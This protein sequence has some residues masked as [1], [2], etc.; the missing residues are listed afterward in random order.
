MRRV[1]LLIAAARRNTDNVDFD[2][3]RGI[4]DES[5]LEW[6]NEGQ[7]KLQA[8]IIGV[9]ADLFSTQKEIA[10]VSQQEVYI[11]PSDTYQNT[12]ALG[13]AFSISGLAKDYYSLNKGS[14]KDRQTGLFGSP[15]RYIPRGKQFL[16]TLVPTT[17]T[18]RVDYIGTIPRLDKRRA[19]V[20]AVTLGAGGITSLT[21]DFAN[22]DPDNYSALT[23]EGFATAVDLDGNQKMLAIPLDAI[24]STTGIVTV[25][26]G[27]LYGVGETLAVGNYLLCGNDSTTHS[28]L[29][30]HCEQYL[31]RTMELYALNKDSSADD[32]EW[33]RELVDLETEIVAG[34]A[35]QN[36]DTSFPVVTDYDYMDQE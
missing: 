9:H 13:V 17:G 28:E 5:F 30:D 24:D 19:K 25:R 21:L 26:A 11:Y 1:D 18:I 33:K 7:N 20:T 27:F 4:S 32:A 22:D 31:R 12:L 8:K 34:Y 29:A 6:V 36:Q 15:S 35:E 23:N 16:L 10:V 2:D 3:D 14:L